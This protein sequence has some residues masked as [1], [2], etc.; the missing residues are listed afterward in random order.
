MSDAERE[1]ALRGIKSRLQAHAREEVAA[2]ITGETLDARWR[3]SQ[4]RELVQA[5]EDYQG[6]VALDP[7]AAPLTAEQEGLV[8]E[9]Q[10]A[11]D[12]I[13]RENPRLTEAQAW[14]AYMQHGGDA[15]AM[16]LVRRQARARNP[17]RERYLWEH[18]L[19]QKYGWAR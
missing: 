7:S 14:I 5:W 4:M 12:R 19:I 13:R 2:E 1:E 17:E 11:H 16:Q 15:E 6:Y 9:A 3:P 18:P 8:A 10:A